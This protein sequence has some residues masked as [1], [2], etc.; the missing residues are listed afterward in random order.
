[1]FFLFLF[2]VSAL[3]FRNSVKWI[4]G[5]YLFV[6][7]GKSCFIVDSRLSVLQCVQ[8]VCSES[9]ASVIIV[10]FFLNRKRTDAT[11]GSTESA[12]QAVTEV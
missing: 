10:I 5:Q 8:G 9:S 7:F 2:I 11:T 3:P 1:M 4:C 12:D 6:C